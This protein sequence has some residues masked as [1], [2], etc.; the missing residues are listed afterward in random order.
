VILHEEAHIQRRDTL[1]QLFVQIVCALVWFQPLAWYAARRAAEERERACDDLVLA[2]GVDTVLYAGHL[3]DI[4]RESVRIPAAAM[5]M[6]RPSSLEVRLRALTNRSLSR[7]P[8]TSRWRLGLMLGLATTALTVSGLRAQQN[9]PVYKSG[10]AGVVAP[11]LT[12][13]V[14]AKYSPGAQARGVMGVVTLSFEVD[15]A[16][17]PRNIKVVE[18]LDPELDKS[19]ETAVGEYRFDP[20]TKEGVPVAFAAVVRVGF[21]LQ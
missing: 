1:A 21:R 6:A 17:K 9:G 16:G 20:A 3:V 12:H 8:L 7:A 11:K 10:D 13:K 4:A 5:G 19:A 2:S 18:G 15:K 14:D